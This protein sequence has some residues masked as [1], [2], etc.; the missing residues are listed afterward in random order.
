MFSRPKIRA[1]DSLPQRH[2]QLEAQA[3]EL[4]RREHQREEQLGAG[5]AAAVRAVDRVVVG[6]DAVEPAAL[7]GRPQGAPILLGADGR[8]RLHLRGQPV[9]ALFREEQVMR[10]DAGGDR[11]IAAD[12]VEQLELGGG[13]EVHEVQGTAVLARHVHEGGA[14]IH[15]VGRVDLHAEDAATAQE[16]VQRRHVDHVVAGLARRRARV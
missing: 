11:Q 4:H 15:R 12:R 2:Q 6:R 8:A 7:H 13:G 10:G 16:P 14:L 5:D 3:A 9:E 1:G